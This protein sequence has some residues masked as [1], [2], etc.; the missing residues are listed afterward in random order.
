MLKTLGTYGKWSRQMVNKDKSTLFL[1]KKIDSNTK[2]G[3]L[4]LL[5]FVEGSFLAI[6]YLGAPPFSGRMTARVL[7][8][9]VHKIQMK[10][11]S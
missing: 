5:G 10:V 6:S 1:S 9:L 3:L 4:Q 7:R 2:R 8:P 11:A